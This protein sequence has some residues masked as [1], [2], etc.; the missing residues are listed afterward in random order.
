MTGTEAAKALRTIH[1]QLP[2]STVQMSKTTAMAIAT[3]IA[4]LGATPAG[5]NLKVHTPDGNRLHKSGL[6]LR[7]TFNF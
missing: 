2:G 6:V 3:A 1:P 4:N 7:A 5:A